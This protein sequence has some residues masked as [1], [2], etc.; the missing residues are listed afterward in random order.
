MGFLIEWVYEKSLGINLAHHGMSKCQPYLDVLRRFLLFL[1][2]KITLR[3][4]TL[5]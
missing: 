4:T 5:E 1:P 2:F 3:D